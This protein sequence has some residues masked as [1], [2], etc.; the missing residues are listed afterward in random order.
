MSLSNEICSVC[1][2][3]WLTDSPE[4]MAY[5][6]CGKC[7]RK[8]RRQRRKQK[9]RKPGM[10]FGNTQ[11]ALQYNDSRRSPK[12]EYGHNYGKPPFSGGPNNM[13]FRLVPEGP[14][15]NMINPND[16]SSLRIK[17]AH[18]NASPEMHQLIS[19][20]FGHEY[21][22]Q[23]GEK[24]L[25]QYHE[26][27]SKILDLFKKAQ[28]LARNSKISRIKAFSQRLKVE[29]Q[30]RKQERKSLEKLELRKR[31]RLDLCRVMPSYPCA[32]DE[33][34]LA[35]DDFNPRRIYTGDKKPPSRSYGNSPVNSPS[36]Y[37]QS[38]T[39]SPYEGD[40]DV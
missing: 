2:S 36:Y 34:E 5:G 17:N 13:N 22:E 39:A 9:K 6:V 27:T 11:P 23:L 18:L 31:G 21:G 1:H 19:E 8:Q 4:Q 29:Q 20:K 24:E 35:V 7:R 40:S 10:N 37:G 28:I 33:A 15:S 3:T 38:R 30:L 25:E 26:Q 12:R 16:G 14:K 32:F